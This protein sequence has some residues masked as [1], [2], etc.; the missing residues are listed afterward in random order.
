MV[1]NRKGRTLPCKTC[2]RAY[3]DII[4]LSVDLEKEG[5]VICARC[6]MGLVD[7]VAYQK[8][9]GE[10]DFNELVDAIRAKKLPK[11]RGKYGFIQSE[12]AKRMGITPRH[13]RRIENSTYIPSSKVLRKIEIRVRNV[14]SA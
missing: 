14:R 3:S 1:Y 13:L 10:I 5:Y 6:C 4:D 9:H 2:G 12:L 8:K 11:F 7:S